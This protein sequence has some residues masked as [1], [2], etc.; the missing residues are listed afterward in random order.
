MAEKETNE[1]N[2]IS[3][4]VVLTDKAIA[5]EKRRIAHKREV[6][7]TMTTTIYVLVLVAAV[8]VL[9][10]TLYM[11]VI[12]VSGNSMNPTLYDGDIVL[13][14]KTDKL[15]LGDLCCFYWNNKLLLKRVIGTPGD[16]IELDI[17]GNL[18]V[19]GEYVDEMYI[20]KKALGECDIE[21]PYQV[22]DNHFFMLGDSREVSIDSRNSTIGSVSEE[23]MVGKVMVRVWPNIEIY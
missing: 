7:K 2:D 19:N 15:E 5:R 1:V 10:S 18:Y 12:K 9:L 14:I 4:A 17:D 16:V 11:P 23:Q 22:G 21:F 20:D 13:L 3:P 8:A 6:F